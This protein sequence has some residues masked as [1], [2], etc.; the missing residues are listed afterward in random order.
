[1]APHQVRDHTLVPR[2]IRARA[3]I[4]ILVADLNA[5]FHAP[6][7][8]KEIPLLLRELLPRQILWDLVELADRF[9]QSREVATATTCPRLNRATRNG[10]LLVGDHEPSIDLEHGAE[11]IAV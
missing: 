1:M 5:S 4:A 6:A 8:Q 10:L 9:D 2:L 3:A 11:T 7:V